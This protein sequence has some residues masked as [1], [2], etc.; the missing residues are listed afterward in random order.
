MPLLDRSVGISSSTV[1]CA[2]AGFPST[3]GNLN[4]E[5]HNP[6]SPLLP[7]GLDAARCPSCLKEEE[8]RRDAVVMP[9]VDKSHQI[10]HLLLQRSHSG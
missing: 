5:E 8:A 3:R 9:T 1:P 7:P 2:T 6:P 10:S 4:I